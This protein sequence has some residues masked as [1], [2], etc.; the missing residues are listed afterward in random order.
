VSRRSDFR[1]GQ[2][3][4]LNTAPFRRVDGVDA[5][6]VASPRLLGRWA[7]EGRIDAGPISLVDS[8]R[9][10]R[11]FEPAGPFVIAVKNAARSVLLFARRTWDALDGAR[12]GVTDQT[13]TSV[14][15]L[16]VLATARDGRRLRLATGFAPE[17]DAR[18]LIG[19]AAL[20]P[21][22]E[23]TRQF[24]YVTDLGEEWNAWRRLPFVF[25]RFMMRRSL[26]ADRKAAVVEALEESLQRFE[27]EGLAPTVSRPSGYTL[28]RASAY[29]AGF[30][31]RAG[32]EEERAAAEFRTWHESLQVR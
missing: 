20:Q 4:Y 27:R 11:D 17:D 19:D 24:P 14:E 23:V 25:A 5:L 18:L 15:L 32:P 8:W 29:L 30:I 28:E 16:R 2:L 13:S 31:Y 9:L 3:A 6:A 7:E 26:D 21:P 1:L 10:E 22:A 12:V